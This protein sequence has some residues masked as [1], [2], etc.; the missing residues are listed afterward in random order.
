MR[1]GD[2]W[3]NLLLIARG[4]WRT[5]NTHWAEGVVPWVWVWSRGPAAAQQSSPA[6]QHTGTQAHRRCFCTQRPPPR[7]QSIPGTR[8]WETG[9][10]RAGAAPAGLVCVTVLYAATA[11]AWS[12][13]IHP[14]RPSGSTLTRLTASSTVWQAGNVTQMRC[15]QARLVPAVSADT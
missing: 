5:C 15:Q 14:P 9:D 4:P 2:R 10:R 11:T 13:A 6:A 12:P 1:R 7:G 3:Q 8:G